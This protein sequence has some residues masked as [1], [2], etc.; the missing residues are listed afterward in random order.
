MRDYDLIIPSDCNC[1]E[2]RGGEPASALALMRK[3]LKG[4]QRGPVDEI[5][6][7]E[8]APKKKRSR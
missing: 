3:F 4:G 1:F 8:R 6:P 2:Y 7:A 5:A